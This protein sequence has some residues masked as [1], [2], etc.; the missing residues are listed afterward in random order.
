MKQ[1]GVRYKENIAKKEFVNVVGGR[2]Q[3]YA[4]TFMIKFGNV[5]LMTANEG[6]G[7]VKLT[8]YIFLGGNL[9]KEDIANEKIKHNEKGLW[10]KTS[11][12]DQKKWGTK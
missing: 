8:K 12:R 10:P 9:H 4:I 5:I 6:K 7:I 3:R 2:T 1:R 11:L